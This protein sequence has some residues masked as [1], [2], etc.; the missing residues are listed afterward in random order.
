MC[1]EAG[2]GPSCLVV[3]RPGRPSAVGR[4][5]GTRVGPDPARPPRLPLLGPAP[6]PLGLA[7]ALPALDGAFRQRQQG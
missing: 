7:V 5:E 2:G 4:G 1:H 3:P 6:A